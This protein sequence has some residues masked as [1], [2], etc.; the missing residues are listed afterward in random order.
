MFHGN[1]SVHL[2]FRRS[3]MA[4]KN[5]G[6]ALGSRKH[7][8]AQQR[9]TPEQ[10]VARTE[11]TFG[12][13]TITSWIQISLTRAESRRARLAKLTMKQRENSELSKLMEI[14]MWVHN[15]GKWK[16]VLMK[17]LSC[18]PISTH[19]DHK[20]LLQQIR[21][22][23]ENG[24]AKWKPTFQKCLQSL[25]PWNWTWMSSRSSPWKVL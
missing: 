5:F 10:V 8:S 12:Q 19:Q 25:K 3:E 2:L 9:R 1:L 20:D 7:P 18:S 6:D 21:V 22:D 11:M 13:P 23:S 17:M 4:R 24:C 14:K 15:L 16:I